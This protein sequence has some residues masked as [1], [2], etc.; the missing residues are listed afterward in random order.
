MIKDLNKVF[1]NSVES[2]EDNKT[3]LK[4]IF[5]FVAELFVSGFSFS[6]KEVIDMLKMIFKSG[7][8][9]KMNHASE[10][11]GKLFIYWYSSY[12]FVTFLLTFGDIFT[13][14]VPVWVEAWQK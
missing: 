11:E 6:Y 5:L 9:K 10:L 3:K 14:K 2:A 12:T 4:A 1:N 13:K 8:F 7:K